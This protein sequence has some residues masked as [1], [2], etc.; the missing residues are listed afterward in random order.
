MNSEMNTRWRWLKIMY[1]Y[2][3]IGAGGFGLAMILFPETVRTLFRWPPQDPIVYGVTGSVWM[4]FGVLSI[5]G[6]RSPLK[7]VP[8][9]MM[10]LCYKSIWFIG[11][12]FPMLFSGTFPLYAI[13]HVVIMGSYIVGDLIAIPFPYV[14]SRT[15]TADSTPTLETA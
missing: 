10:Q 7:F 6:L 3:I 2:T 8:I 11:V 1:W 14:F 13:L 5:F 9:L 4:A 12:V 15:E